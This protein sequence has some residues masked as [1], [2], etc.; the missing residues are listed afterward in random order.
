MITEIKAEMQ[1]DVDLQNELS[2]IRES[3]EEFEFAEILDE[4]ERASKSEDL[5]PLRTGSYFL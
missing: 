5:A 4:A 1:S 3:I 2:S